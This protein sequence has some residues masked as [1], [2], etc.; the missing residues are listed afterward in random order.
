VFNFF[1]LSIAELQLTGTASASIFNASA[2]NKPRISPRNQLPFSSDTNGRSPSPSVKKTA[3]KLCSLD[4]LTAFSVSSS[5]IASV[6]I[7]TKWSVSSRA[8]T[9][10]PSASKTR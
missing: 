10:A 2:H 3:S 1:L 5:E 9:S 6:S 4:Q 8:I 7:G